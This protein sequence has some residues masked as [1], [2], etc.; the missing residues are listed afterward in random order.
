M[1]GVRTFVLLCVASTWVAPP[2]DAQVSA[3]GSIEIRLAT[4]SDLE[5]QG[6]AQLERI[7]AKWDLSRWFFTHTVQIQS[8]VIPH[9]HPVLTLNTNSLTNDSIK[10]QSFIHEQ[11]H[12]FLSRH[13]AATDSA[14]AELQQ[15]YPDVPSEGASDHESTYLHLLVGMLEFDALSELFDEA[16]A[17]R[18]LG[19][20]PFYTRIYREVLERPDPIRSILRKYRL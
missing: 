11:L 19:R 5:K 8:G 18:R 7:L 3:P 9:S 4:G 1:H 20:T 6:R 10:V 14:K 17:R 12:W 13:R 16:A 15:L 2:F